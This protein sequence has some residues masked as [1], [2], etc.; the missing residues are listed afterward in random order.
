MSPQTSAQTTSGE[1]LTGQQRR[2]LR[3]LIQP[4]RAVVQIGSAGI[5]ESVVKAVDAALLDHELIK[6]RLLEPEDKHGAAE[7]LALASGAHL[8]GVVGHTLILY[9]RHPESPRIVLPKPASSRAR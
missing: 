3:G 5:T 2:F 1:R 6:V 9:R 8:C 4:R 7:S